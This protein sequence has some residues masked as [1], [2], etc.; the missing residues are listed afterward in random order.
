MVY[1]ITIIIM[2]I[3]VY[4]FD[5]HNQNH[6][7][8]LW[9]RLEWA[10]LVFIAGLRYKIGGDTYAYMEYFETVPDIFQITDSDFKYSRFQPLFI[11]LV[12]F[13]R[14]F[15]SCFLVFQLCHA[16]LVNSAFFYFFRRNSEY[17]F[18]AV[19]FYALFF[20]LNYNTEVG[21]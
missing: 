12:S 3:G 19:L 9:Y 4:R 8:T 13:I 6:N 21:S 2:L 7:K 5:I 15:S 20:F 10:I 1:A 16:I 14:S 18:T 11:I 17:P